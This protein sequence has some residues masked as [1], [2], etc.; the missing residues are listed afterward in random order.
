MVNKKTSDYLVSH[1]N[2]DKSNF[3]T[4]FFYDKHIPQWQLGLSK[5]KQNPEVIAIHFLK[6]HIQYSLN[7]YNTTQ[8]D[9]LELKIKNEFLGFLYLYFFLNKYNHKQS[10]K[11]SF[12]SIE[13]NKWVWWTHILLVKQRIKKIPL[14]Q[15]LEKRHPLFQYP[16]NQIYYTFYLLNIFGG[17]N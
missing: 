10:A 2:K 11:E 1:S 9:K 3:V 13:I 5:L 17:C 4:I 6:G 8:Q 7:I 12:L 16:L 15:G 14:N